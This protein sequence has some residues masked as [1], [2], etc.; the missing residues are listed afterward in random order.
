MTESWSNWFFLAL[1]KPGFISV[2]KP[3]VPL[4]VTGLSA[5]LFGINTWSVLLPSAL[6]GAAAVAVL[7]VVVRR[8]FGLVAAT[9]AAL[10][11][12]VSP[13]NVAVNRLNLPE[14][15]LILFLLG[16]V[17]AVQ[18]ALTSARSIRWLLLAG[19]FVGLAFNTKMLA[20]Y[21]VVPG[22]GMAVLLGSRTWAQ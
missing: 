1:D 2:D 15:W 17:W 19:T 14:A 22:L 5:R 4:W 13:V 7:W 6:A 11:L 20:A 10:V 12:A 16:A 9:V 21:L 8:Q 3:P 18:H